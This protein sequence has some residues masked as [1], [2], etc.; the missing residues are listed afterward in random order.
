MTDS[1]TTIIGKVQNLLGDASATYFTTAVVTAAVRQALCEWND[2]APQLLAAL[3]TGV[4]DQ[5]EYELSDEDA[6]ALGIMDILQ[7]GDNN[8][9]LDVS[10]SYDTYVEDE[11]IFFRLRAP[12]TT[13]DTLIVTYNKNHIINGLDSQVESTLPA[14]YDQAIVNGG[15]YFAI[16]IRATSRVETNNLDKAV[17]DNYRELAPMFG[18][19]FTRQ[20]T[21]AATRKAKVGEPDMRAWNDAYHSWEQ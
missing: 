4:N 8:N 2:K 12:V 3:I 14:Y 16:A 9:E 19:Y 5:Y 18:A 6:D 1:L 15:A 7:Q 21:K 17:M 20:I 10:L 13:S 11:R